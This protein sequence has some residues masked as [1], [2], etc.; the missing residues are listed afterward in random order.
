MPIIYALEPFVFIGNLIVFV[1]SST[2]P[3]YSEGLSFFSFE[4]ASPIFFPKVNV[5][6]ESLAETFDKTQSLPIVLIVDSVVSKSCS[7]K[8][9]F[10]STYIKS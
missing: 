7:L 3:K 5:T 10:S 2:S 9:S 4:K 8:N 1:S 6:V